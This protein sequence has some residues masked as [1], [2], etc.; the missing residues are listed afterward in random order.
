VR[1]ETIVNGN[2]DDIDEGKIVMS[3]R[4]TSQVEEIAAKFVF[5]SGMAVKRIPED[6]VI[7]KVTEMMTKSYSSQNSFLLS[8]RPD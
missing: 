5:P 2:P 6:K 8:L 4:P 7:Q 3:V 1:E